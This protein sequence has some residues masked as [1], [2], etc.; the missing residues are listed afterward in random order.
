MLLVDTDVLIDVLRGH[1]PAIAWFSGLSVIPSVPGFV[2]M[3][4]IQGLSDE[5]Q[6]Q[7]MFV[8][9]SWWEITPHD[10]NRPRASRSD[11]RAA[12]LVQGSW[13]QPGLD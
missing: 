8:G 3:E 10:E 11:Q 1:Q 13:L 9:A 12:S 6:W 5:R 2:V 4:L 7:Q